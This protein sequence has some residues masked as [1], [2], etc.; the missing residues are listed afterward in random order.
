MD[1][2]QKN[3]KIL[4]LLRGFAITG[5]I[6]T[7]AIVNYILQIPLPIVPLASIIAAFI[8]FNIFTYNRYQ[9]DSEISQ[10]EITVQILVDITILSLLLFYTGGSTNPFISLLILPLLVALFI[11][12]TLHCILMLI[13]TAIL[14][15]ILSI[16]Y[17]PIP[18]FLHYHLGGFFSLHLQGMFISYL[19]LAFAIAVFILRIRKNIKQNEDDIEYLV[20]QS[21]INRN[22]ERIALIAASYSHKINTP[23]NTI[24]LLS[25]MLLKQAKEGKIQEKDLKEDLLAI[26]EETKK[27]SKTLISLLNNFSKN[28]SEQIIILPTAKFLNEFKEL[29]GMNKMDVELE[30]ENQ[31]DRNFKLKHCE[32]IQEVLAC[33]CDNAYEAD[34]RKIILKIKNNKQN[35]EFLVCDNG[36]GMS[37]KVQKHLGKARNS[38]KATESRKRGFGFFIAKK[39]IDK[40]GGRIILEKTDNQGTEIRFFL[41]LS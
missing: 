41:P 20:N 26:N 24:S 12:P 37:D 6:V 25:E 38:S 31:T 14:Y 3:L 16:Y 22:M 34:A 7:I 8:I 32:L 5:Q 29:W 4:L 28:S 13:L 39:I 36:T 40:L 18:H 30:I 11:L 10:T 15:V 2:N 9:K 19:I 33:F 27:A 17:H 1:L 35:V 21:L 23:L